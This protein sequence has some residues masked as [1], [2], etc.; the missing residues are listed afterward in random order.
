MRPDDM[1]CRVAAEELRHDLN[2]WPTRLVEDEEPTDEDLYPEE[3][4]ERNQV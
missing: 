2:T 1:P 4:D 3:T